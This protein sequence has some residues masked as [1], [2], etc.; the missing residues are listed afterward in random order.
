VD[1]NGIQLLFSY[2]A[3]SPRLITLNMKSFISAALLSAVAVS[4]APGLVLDV[5]GKYHS[6]REYITHTDQ[7]I[8]TGPSSVVNVDGLT[9]K[10]TLKNTGDETLKVR[11]PHLTLTHHLIILQLLNDPRTVLTTAKTNT[12][13]ISSASGSPSFTGIKAKYVPSKAVEL[14]QANTFTVLAPG[15][16][17]EITHNLAGVYNFT[18]AGEGAYTVSFTLVLVRIYILICLSRLVRCRKRFQLRRRL[19][20]VEDDR[21]CL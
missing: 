2:F 10:A 13:S 16:S 15:Q 14:N 20:C 12:F 3:D 4:A 21:G 18:S 11:S 1:L 19:G 7:Y 6:R 8:H 9:V 5:A 17:I